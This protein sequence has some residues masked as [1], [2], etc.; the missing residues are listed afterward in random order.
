MCMPVGP[1]AAPDPRAESFLALWGLGGDAATLRQRRAL[2]GARREVPSRAIRLR[3]PSGLCA[4]FNPEQRLHASVLLNLLLTATGGMPP[5]QDAQ[6]HADVLDRLAYS[7][8]RYLSMFRLT[9]AQAPF[10]LDGL[11]E[12]WWRYLT[13]ELRLQVCARCGAA[14]VIERGLEGA[15]CVHCEATPAP[16]AHASGR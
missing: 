9:E 13:H 11:G 8:R 10:S 6:G 14:S 3:P 16:A 15:P 1:A 2:Q 5:P 12:L 7:Y 4:P